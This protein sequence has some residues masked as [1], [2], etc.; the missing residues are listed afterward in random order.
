MASTVE[1][2]LILPPETIAAYRRDGAVLVKNLLSDQDLKRLENGLEEAH[3][4]PSQM[5]SRYTG[6]DDSGE[7][8][9]DQFPGERS[10]DLRILLEQGPCAELAARLMGTPS[11]QLVLDQMFYK[12]AGQVLAT[13]WHQ[14]TPF[15]RVRGS[16]MARVWLPCDPSPAGV[17][18]E[19]VRGSHLWNVVYDTSGRASRSDLAKADEG[20]AFSYD[21][22][23]EDNL[24]PLPD[25]DA[26]R[27]SF[28]II[29]W[30]VEPGDAVVFDGNILHGASGRANHPLKRRAFACMF[31]GPDLQ[32]QGEMAQGMP[33]PDNSDASTVPHGARIGDHPD[34]FPVVWR[35]AN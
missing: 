29:S 18:L 12:D 34:V 30:D 9:V 17:T 20:D 32:Y 2:G 26:H 35:E 11:A 5:F 22:V 19:V 4:A 23:G 27:D 15:L 24:P 21:G 6:G 33:L 16:Q 3:N 7:T 13:P 10:A 14:D 31:G 25:I 8:F 1:K 28:D